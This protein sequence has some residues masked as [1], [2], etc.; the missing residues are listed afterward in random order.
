VG[1]S[2]PGK[3]EE[4]RKRSGALDDAKGKERAREIEEAKPDGWD[5]GVLAYANFVCSKLI[6]SDATFNELL[7]R[8]EWRTPSGVRVAEDEVLRDAVRTAR[9]RDLAVLVGGSRGVTLLK[10][11]PA[12]AALAERLEREAA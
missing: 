4:R 2:A 5:A 11:T 8:E 10:A 3:L 9:S 7:L 12:G 1:V 6:R